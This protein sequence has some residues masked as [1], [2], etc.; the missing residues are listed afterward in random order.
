MP[1]IVLATLNARYAHA[2][3]GLRCLRANMGELRDDTVIREFVIRTPPE[4]IVADLIAQQPRIVGLG[5]YI[6][7]VR[8]TT[9]VVELLKAAAP[10]VVVVLGGPEVS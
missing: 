6:W 5:V 4:Q 8:Q 1:S 9:R 3:L 2:S 10:H 7:N